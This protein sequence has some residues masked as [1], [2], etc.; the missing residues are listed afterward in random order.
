MYFVKR[1]GTYHDVAGASFRDLMAGTLPSLPDERATL[2][3]WNNHLTTIFTE[4]RLK[5]FLEMRGADGGGGRLICAVPALWVGLLYDSVS[6]DGAW[7]IVKD[8]TADER[9]A[10]RE[11]VPVTA[12][13]TP[14]R[15]RT[16]LDIARDVVALARQGL[17]RRGNLNHEGLDE[18]IY[19]SVLEEIVAAGDTP[20]DRKLAE[21]AA[22]WNGSVDPIY[23]EYAY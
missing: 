10:L 15:N 5:R 11:G 13:A 2:A 14:M 8:W 1:G 21:Y 22:E 7:E 17:A 23:T 6:L 16:V 3:D 9:Q 18:S 20:A 19:I 12:L 4:V